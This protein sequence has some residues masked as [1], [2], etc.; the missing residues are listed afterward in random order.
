MGDRRENKITLSLL[1]FSGIDRIFPEE[2]SAPL[3]SELNFQEIFWSLRADSLPGE[4]L[5]NN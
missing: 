2:A 3:N 5:G 4:E 1:K